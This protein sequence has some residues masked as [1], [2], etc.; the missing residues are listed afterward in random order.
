ME[1]TYK[2]CVEDK[3]KDSEWEWD[4]GMDRMGKTFILDGNFA[5]VPCLSWANKTLQKTVLFK[6]LQN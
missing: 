6:E 1:A 5:A 3:N 4:S 2:I